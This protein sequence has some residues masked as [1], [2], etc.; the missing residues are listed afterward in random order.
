MIDVP[1]LDLYL[2]TVYYAWNSNSE[3]YRD[4]LSE[5]LKSWVSFFGVNRGMIQRFKSTVERPEFGFTFGIGK[6]NSMYGNKEIRGLFDP[7]LLMP[8]PFLK[9][10][11]RL[12]YTYG[13]L[14]ESPEFDSHEYF[15]RYYPKMTVRVFTK[16]D[17]QGKWI[18]MPSQHWIIGA[19]GY[20]DKNKKHV[21]CYNVAVAVDLRTIVEE[22]LH[23]QILNLHEKTTVAEVVKNIEEKKP[24]LKKEIEANLNRILSTEEKKFMDL[25]ATLRVE[26]ASE[27]RILEDFV[28]KFETEVIYKTAINLPPD[29]AAT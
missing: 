5:E 17:G 16:Q 14:K 8:A 18:L 22:E 26:H 12:L 11:P 15:F 3:I 1:E 28:T 19:H 20:D 24:D 10:Y 13:F 4:I 21:I 7:M 25:G 23:A 2:K 9:I 6:S 29:P 27:L